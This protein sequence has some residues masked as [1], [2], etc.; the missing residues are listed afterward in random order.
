MPSDAHDGAYRLAAAFALAFALASARNEANVVAAALTIRARATTREF[1]NELQEIRNRAQARAF[2]I[3]VATAGALVATKPSERS[4]APWFA[5]FASSIAKRES[6]ETDSDGESATRWVA[7]WYRA[8]ARAAMSDGDER[9]VSGVMKKMETFANA[10]AGGRLGGRE[11]KFEDWFVTR[12]A[13]VDETTFFVGVANL[14]WGPFPTVARSKKA[15]KE[16]VEMYGDRVAAAF[17][18]GLR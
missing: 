12:V 4:F 10:L 13:T 5:R 16:F 9:G 15:A 7:R 3:A 8:Y 17:A 18:S 14:W 1:I 2:T 11:I 6:I